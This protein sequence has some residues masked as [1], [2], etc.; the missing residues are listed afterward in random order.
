MG[1]PASIPGNMC[2]FVVRWLACCRAIPL[3]IPAPAKPRVLG[4]G[5]HLMVEFATPCM[6]RPTSLPCHLL[7]VLDMHVCAADALSCELPSGCQHHS[8]A[9]QGLD[10]QIVIKDSA[11]AAEGELLD[12]HWGQEVHCRVHLEGRVRF[13]GC[14]Q[15]RRWRAEV[16]REE[17]LGELSVATLTSP[18]EAAR[19]VTGAVGLDVLS[20]VSRGARRVSDLFQDSWHSMVM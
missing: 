5:T 18:G 19:V 3:K 8:L 9:R 20:L 15:A 4:L 11:T 13:L 6:S 14:T 12:H 10:A 7:V 1:I 16:A 17:R 2:L